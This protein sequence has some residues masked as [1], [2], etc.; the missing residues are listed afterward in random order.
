MCLVASQSLARA[1]F[2]TNPQILSI[3]LTQTDWGLST[4]VVKN[5]DVVQQFNPATYSM[6]GQTAVLT[7]VEVRLDYEFDNT[8]T[9]TLANLS[10]SA[11]ESASGS[12]KLLLP[13]QTNLL[14]TQTF[15]NSH[16][17]P[18]PQNMLMQTW[19]DKFTGSIMS[20]VGG[21]TD[22]TL[23]S[24]FKGT[25]RI[26]PPVDAMAVSSFTGNDATGSSTD[27]ASASISFFYHYILLPIPEP[28]S[29]ALLGMGGLA[30]LW[31][32]RG[33]VF[34]RLPV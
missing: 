16:S 27:T 11:T 34:S 32:F 23:L 31:R 5:A 7:A 10:S 8:I 6:P 12:I 14:P 1:D 29:L 33:R 18:G 13:N 20:P 24:Q 19:S 15:S 4:P 28:S 21:F 3:P 26:S 17:L 9:I 22:P 30:L 2:V 25:S